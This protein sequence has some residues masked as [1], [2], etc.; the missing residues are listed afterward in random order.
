LEP[1]TL[2]Y[3]QAHA[4]NSAGETDGDVLS[5]TTLPICEGTVLLLTPNGGQELVAGSTYEIT[6]QTTGTIPSVL[7]EY[8]AN[9]GA[10]WTDVNTVANTG[11]YQWEVPDVNNSQ[12]CLVRVSGAACPDVNDT[13]DAV[14]TIYR[15][16]LVYDLNHDCIVN[17]V[18]RDL[19][20]SEWLLCG[21]PFDPNCP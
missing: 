19:L 16:T 13:S 3:F 8:S 9:N 11:S 5:F 12:Q 2:Y 4:K 17:E 21:D 1:S 20:L 10:G 6:W 7:I 15:C 18:D 14:F